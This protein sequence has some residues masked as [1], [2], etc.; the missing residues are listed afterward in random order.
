[1]DGMRYVFLVVVGLLGCEPNGGHSSV[2]LRCDEIEGVLCLNSEA[3]QPFS[4]HE[5]VCA[6]GTPRC[7]DDGTGMGGVYSCEG[8]DDL[9]VC[10]PRAN[11]DAGM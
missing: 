3:P 1:M 11:A 8:S 5:A 9:P 10:V 6:E 2:R 4:T 7:A